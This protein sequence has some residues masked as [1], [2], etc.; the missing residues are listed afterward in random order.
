MRIHLMNT[1]WR[2]AMLRTSLGF[3]TLNIFKRIDSKQAKQLLSD[4]MRY[5]DA[6]NEITVY[7]PKDEKERI[8]SAKKFRESTH[9]KTL[10]LPQKWKIDYIHDEDK[11]ISWTLKYFTLSSQFKEYIIEA[12]INPKILIGI[13]DYI[14]AAVGDHLKFAGQRFD[15]RTEKISRILGKFDFYK[16][17]RVDF[18]INFDLME[19]GI[20][21]TPEQM[22][23]LIRMGDCPNHYNEWQKYDPVAR[24]KKGSKFSYYLKSG[25]VNIN[26][27][28]K[29]YQLTEEFPECPNIDDALHVIRFE[30]QCLYRKVY[31][32]SKILE[33]QSKDGSN[34]LIYSIISDIMATD[35]IERYFNQTI[36][37]GDYYSL[38]AAIGIVEDQ[39][40]RPEK[41]E[42]LITA[43]K[44]VNQ[45]RGI[46]KSKDGLNIKGL[47][48]LHQS[49]RELEF[50]GVNPA[51]IPKSFGIKH[52]PN[53]L[54]S[55]CKLRELGGSTAFPF[56]DPFE[57]LEKPFF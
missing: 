42:R 57:P 49:L 48:L 50:I 51:T 12:R 4:F 27:Y 33:S 44:W 46:A 23:R 2:I 6:T 36:G 54:D 41:E 7:I 34:H 31:T 5:R 24:R 21:C 45:C 20:N 28:Y 56:I 37:A 8:E 55:Y 25:S 38:Q 18:C 39:G 43:L 1:G 9:I 3:H 15:E 52:I 17:K 13:Q 29:H 32:M 30:V 16:L 53:L 47:S 22:M 19:L 35:M 40:F 14:S 10:I 11:G 26:C